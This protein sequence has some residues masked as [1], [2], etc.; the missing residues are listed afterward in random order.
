MWPAFAIGFA[1]LEIL[2]VWREWHR[3]EFIA[4]PAAMAALFGWLATSAGLDGPPLWFGVGLLFSLAGDVFLIRADRFFLPG[5][6][7]FMAAHLAYLVGFNLPLPGFSVWGLFLAVVI[8]LGAARLLRRV[9]AGARASGQGAMVM[10]MTL[11]GGALTLML[12]SALLTL[13][14][15][16][17]ETWASALVALGAAFFFLSDNVLAWNKFVAPLPRGRL[18]NIITYELGQILLIAGVVRQFM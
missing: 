7:A 13:S 9:V 3:L 6:F 14:N 18:M 2:A 8:G 11:Y 5:L 16:A 1:L 15:L 4:K 17:W 12:L 10:P